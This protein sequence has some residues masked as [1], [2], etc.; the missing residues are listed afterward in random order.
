MSR[1]EPTLWKP[2]P[3]VLSKAP[4]YVC[5][6]QNRDPAAR[7]RARPGL[8]GDFPRDGALYM[9]EYKP[10]NKKGCSRPVRRYGQVRAQAYS[11]VSFPG[12]DALSSNPADDYGGLDPTLGSMLDAD[13]RTI[14]RTLKADP[15]TG[16]RHLPRMTP[17]DGRAT[18]WFQGMT[19]RRG[20]SLVMTDVRRTDDAELEFFS[21]DHLKLHFKL[22]GPSAI[23]GATRENTVVDPGVMAFLVQPPKTVKYEI[24]EAEERMRCITMVCSREFAGGLLSATDG[25]LPA[26]ITEFL[27]GPSSRFAYGYAPLAPQLRALVEEMMGLQGDPLSRLMLEAKAL[28]LLYLSLRQLS[29]AG[30]AAAPRERDRRKVQDLCALLDSREGAAMSIAQLCRTLAWNETQMMEAFK[31]ITG[32]TIA[33]Y[34]QRLRMEHALHQLRTTD[35]SI[36]EIAFDAGYEHPSNFATAFKRTFG[37]SPRAGR[38]RLN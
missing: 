26:A 22:E 15:V 19:V 10:L 6:R 3:P 34:R 25:D 29:G 5:E 38:A 30:A 13:G 11:L 28:E 27:K 20:F 4:K 8:E 32:T 18:G 21:D 2:G 23:S 24:M 31:Q 33:N 35:L 12:G 16:M 37:F 36:T 17:S 1:V 14:A 7:G 9:N